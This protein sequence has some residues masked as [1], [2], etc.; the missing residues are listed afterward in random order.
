MANG[1]FRVHLETAGGKNGSDV[2]TVG[3]HWWGISLDRIER[4]SHL[5]LNIALWSYRR[6]EIVRLDFGHI[7]LMNGRKGRVEKH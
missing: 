1:P 3:G 5:T 6:M 4:H 2:V 7:K